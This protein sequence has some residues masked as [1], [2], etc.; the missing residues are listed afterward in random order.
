MSKG[1]APWSILVG[2][3]LACDGTA[4]AP[5]ASL[6]PGDAGAGADAMGAGVP[7]GPAGPEVEPAPLPDRL[8]RIA[9]ALD[10]ALFDC[11]DRVWPGTA[12]SYGRS[13][14]LLVSAREGTAHLWNDRRGAVPGQRPRVSQLATADL[15]PEWRTLFHVD[16]LFGSPT[17]GI[18]LDETA[19]ID[20]GLAR[21]GQP[22][23]HEL[24]IEL[25]LHEAFHFIGSQRDWQLAGPAGTRSIP[26]PE[27]AGPRYLRAAL[28]RALLGHLR[29]GG[30]A[31][32]LA[33]AAFW[34]GRFVAEHGEDAEALLTTDIHE[35]TAEYAAIAGSAIVQHGCAA[36]EA[37][38]VEAMVAHLDGFVKVDRFDGGS[39]SYQLGV[40]A[41][42][43]A[44]AR[45][46]AAA[47]WEGRV[48]TGESPVQV[49]LGAT[50]AAPQPDDPALDSGARAIVDARNA[51]IALEVTPLLARMKS[52]DHI[53]LPIP[54]SWALGSFG[55]SE[56][57]TLV[58]EPGRPDV[59]L[60]Y[61]AN[62]RAPGGGPTI[63]VMQSVMEGP[64][65]CDASFDGARV[66]TFPAA[67]VATPL[68]GRYTLNSAPVRFTEL[69]ATLVTD[70]AGLTWMCPT[71]SSPPGA[72]TAPGPAPAAP[73]A[74]RCD[75]QPLLRR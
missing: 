66:A 45:G 27:R 30:G 65:G 10:T 60:D 64:N 31:A 42:V 20:D 74:L 4:S 72:L 25:T 29:T 15:G 13:Q 3:L 69:S 11:P 68:P 44:R 22:R 40:L 34:Q 35:G 38:L 32:S 1:A 57:I 53:R 54:F 33:A 75:P 18:S 24:A 37:T 7:G 67:A 43:A 19:R 47:G 28:A 50:P 59:L 46:A 63:A 56:F 58:D 26:Y 41:G 62:H 70:A 8:S 5:D 23:W 73:P 16:E 36:S 6:S 12:A 9:R 52:S 2:L 48:E 17:L 61:R 49:L 14:I 51:E 21:S 39:E 71:P 55:V